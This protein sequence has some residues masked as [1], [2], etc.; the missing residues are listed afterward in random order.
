M[1]RTKQSARRTPTPAEERQRK[2]EIQAENERQDRLA[3]ESNAKKRKSGGEGL[4]SGE[5]S[6]GEG[7]SSG[8]ES[9]VKKSKRKGEEEE[10]DEG[11]EGDEG[12]YVIYSGEFE[13]PLLFQ[14]Y[15]KN[16]PVYKPLFPH[17][18][19]HVTPIML[20][21]ERTAD[22]WIRAFEDPKL[23]PLAAAC[24]HHVTAD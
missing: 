1:A 16:H 21:S 22:F 4:S 10:E 9:G 5:E 23:R 8:E 15:I 18:P 14:D 3:E 2:L 7:L 11:D 17:M 20:K 6:G 12:D 13:H 24:V 19:P